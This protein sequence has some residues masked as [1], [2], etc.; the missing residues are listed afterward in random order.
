MPDALNNRQ[1]QILD[2]V[3]KQGF[4]ATD[5]LVEHFNVTPQTIRR[6]INILC[7]QDLLQRFHGGAGASNSTENAPYERRLSA[8]SMA[9]QAIAR[10][11]AKHIPN[12]ASLFLNIGTT[13]EMVASALLNHHD[14]KIV[15]NNLHV[16]NILSA[17]PNFDVMIAGGHLRSRDGGIVGPATTDFIKQF[18]LDY[19]VIGVSG[20]DEEGT[21]LDFDYQ[22]TRNAEAIIANS[23]KTIL[24][25]D[26]SKF[27]RKAMT[28]FGHLSQIDMVFT[29]KSPAAPFGKLL[30][31]C[32]VETVIC[33]APS[34]N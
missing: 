17:Q 30:N 4:V 33:K 14:L 32:N 20:I 31:D 23:Q 34:G 22:E 6:D 1:I 25:C 29:D 19:G 13:T 10:E 27:G 2:L 21:L 11:V 7:D 28:K 5:Q 24:V 12:G 18:R 8:Y 9:K 16:A 26:H 3:G 15:T